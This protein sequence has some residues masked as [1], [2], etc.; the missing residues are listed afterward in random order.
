MR[1]R[2]LLAVS[3]HG[4]GHLAQCAPVVDALRARRPN[5]ELVIRSRLPR[6]VLARRIAEPFALQPADDDF[7]MVMHDAIRVD[8][9]ASA[10]RYLALHA[11]WS[12]RVEAAAGEIGEAGPD[13]VLADVPYL[14][15]AA[16]A[17][18]DVR[19]LAMCSLNWYDIVGHYCREIPGMDEVLAQMHA[20]YASAEC[21]LRVTPGMAMEALPNVYPVGP[22]ACRGR[23]R[24]AELEARLEIGAGERVVL[25]ALGGIAS[26]LPVEAWPRVPGVKWLIQRDWHVDH[27]DGRPLE[28]LEMPIADVIASVDALVG[29]PGYG[30]FVEAAAADTPLLYLPRPDWP[31]SPCLETWLAT[32]G[33][34]REI[35][36]QQGV[37]LIRGTMWGVIAAWKE[38]QPAPEE[39]SHC[40][41]RVLRVLK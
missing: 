10:A 28:A 33:R 7:G 19:A 29:K 16:A 11:D 4:F 3:G 34:C 13:L 5:L 21:F 2:L 9:E 32:V 8:A 17:H 38:K 23:R 6:E 25:V 40:V 18:A 37:Q 36:P 20:A 12:S 14:A 39:I 26:R 1:A 31:E 22:V 41:A 35:T 27:P 15:L 24:R 30:T